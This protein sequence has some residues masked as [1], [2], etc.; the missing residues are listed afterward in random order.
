MHQFGYGVPKKDYMKSLDWY[1]RSAAK[2]CARAE[3]RIGTFYEQ[4][5][6]GL[7]KDGS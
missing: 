4:G 6:G 5:L 2:S 7:F 3:G 1:K